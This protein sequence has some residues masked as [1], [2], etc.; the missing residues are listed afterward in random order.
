VDTLAKTAS[1]FGWRVWAYCLVDDHYHLLV[2]TPQPNLSRGMR[3]LNGV[4]TQAFNRR[5]GRIGHLNY[6]FRVPSPHGRAS[7]ALEWGHSVGHRSA[8][9]GTIRPQDGPVSLC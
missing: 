1:R 5:H 7:P 9:R 6:A 3:E 2:E 8:D 4:Y